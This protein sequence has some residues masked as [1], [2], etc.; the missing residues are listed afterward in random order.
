MTTHSRTGEI[1]L[2]VFLFI[3]VVWLSLLIAQSIGDGGITQIAEN[4]VQ[5]LQNPFQIVWT[6]HSLKVLLLCS[7]IYFAGFFVYINTKRNTRN[8]EE[9]GSARWASPQSV[10]AQFK[11][12]QSIILTKNVRLGLNTHKH[13]RNLNVLV[14]GGSGASKTRGFC[15]P[16]I[17][18]ANTNYV[19]TD[20]KS[21]L[22]SS[23]GGF[24]KQ[25]GYELRVLNLVNMEQSDGFNP[26]VYLRDEKDALRLV[27]TLI[28][29]TTPK[30]SRESDPFWVKS[31]TALLQAIVLFLF[32]EAP[33]KE[34][35]FSMV[36]KILEY[37]E[38]KEDDE[39][40]ISAL[41]MMF[42]ALE[43]EQPEHI[44]I[45]QYKVFKQARGRTAMSIIVSAAV[46]LAAFNLPQIQDLSSHDDMDLYTLGEKKV[47]LFAVI[48]DND[49][50][51]HFLVSLLYACAFQSLYYSADQIHGGSLPRH[52]RFVLDEFASMPLSGYTRELATMRSRN[53]SSD[54]II[55]NIAQIKELYKD[56][57][58][59]ILGNSD[60]ILF[61]GGNESSTHKL[62][63]TALGKASIFTKSHGQSSGRSGS[64]STNTQITGRELL[65]P[66]EVRL[67]DNKYAILLI[68]GVLPV[69]DKKYNLMHHKNIRYTS[70]GGA[71]PYVHKRQ[72]YEGAS[73]VEKKKESLH[74]TENT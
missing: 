72:I 38:A 6:K 69:M 43:K 42:L 73:L 71:V 13:G 40:Y 2:C 32:Y 7:A 34:Q 48:P 46:R 41:D 56:S 60:T 37:A 24:L 35:N 26:F 44:A 36:A 45:R 63:S 61:L 14:I 39:D 18:S 31:E 64:Y 27:N 3:P 16:A 55:Q 11:Q 10:N 49:N 8:G 22:L 74:E 54:T 9:H 50:T 65:T 51:F 30:G 25:Q 5:S 29:A 62:I 52:V 58:E 53:I 12:K 28:Q 67:L 23:T 47:A 15:K 70:D 33:E 57:W 1:L 66:D 20:P 17:L 4:F 21:E 59:T 68:R 19:I